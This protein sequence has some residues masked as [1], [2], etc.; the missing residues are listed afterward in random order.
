M[1]AHVSISGSLLRPVR[2]TEYLRGDALQIFASN[3]RGWALPSPNPDGEAALATECEQRGWPL[4]VHAPYLVNVASPDPHVYARSTAS[5]AAATRRAA[6]L[7]ARGV[8]VHA[9]SALGADV[10]AARLRAV[11]AIL[12]AVEAGE[13][14]ASNARHMP[15]VPD[16]LVELTA[17][18]GARSLAR[19]VVD[20]AT[21]I[22]ACGSQPRVGVCLDTCH[23]WAAGIDFKST[24]GMREL[25]AEVRALGVGRLR[26]LHVND[27]KD[28]LGSSRD[29]HANLGKGTI[30][31]DGIRK[32]LDVPEWRGITA[33][34]ETPGPEDRRRSDVGLVHDMARG[35][36]RIRGSRRTH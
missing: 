35:R 8:V 1:G 14:E 29:R 2:E 6:R 22:D 31:I 5:L 32:A 24:G 18:G 4:Y 7:G 17:G 21:I 10:G 33:I 27:S 36:G 15:L 30:G 16:V 11:E 26:L 19:R 34:V 23:L 9:G 13:H 20:A 12:R 25:R 3:P 28:P